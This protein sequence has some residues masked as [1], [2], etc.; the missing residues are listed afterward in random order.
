MAEIISKK[1]VIKKGCLGQ[2]IILKWKIKNNSEIN[3][4]DKP[5]LKDFSEYKLKKFNH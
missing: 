5:L 3:W 2:N 4:P 1:E